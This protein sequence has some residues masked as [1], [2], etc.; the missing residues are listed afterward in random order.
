MSVIFNEGDIVHVKSG[1]PLMTIKWAEGTDVIC[2]WFEGKNKKERRFLASTV[3][4]ARPSKRRPKKRR[5]RT[6]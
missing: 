2:V 3:T 6:E 1:G 5:S 4:H